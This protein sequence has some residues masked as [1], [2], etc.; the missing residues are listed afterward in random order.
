MG[1]FDDTMESFTYS[2]IHTGTFRELA[3]LRPV[4]PG[5]LLVQ[6]CVPIK[7]MGTFPAHVA[8]TVQ[9]GLATIAVPTGWIIPLITWRHPIRHNILCRYDGQYGSVDGLLCQEGL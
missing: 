7:P 1:A 9:L 8:S 2:V 5:P 4:Y 6:N 3:K